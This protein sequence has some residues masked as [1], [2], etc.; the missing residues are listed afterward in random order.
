MDTKKYNQYNTIL[1]WATFVIAALVYTL[2]MEPTASFWDCGEFITTS[3]KLE[4]GHPP[5]APFFM[6]LGRIFSLFAFGD[7]S[8]V[9]MMINLLSALASAFTILFLFWSLTHIARKI[10]VKNEKISLTNTILIFGSAFVGALAYTFSDTFWFSAV[11]GEV[12]ALSS[13]FTAVVFWAILKWENEA[14]SQHANRWLIL[15][16]YL[17]G[18]S[19]G[20][21]LLNLLAIP[22]I[23]FV[24]YFKKH[25]TDVKGIVYASL[26]SIALL[27]GIMYGIIP[28]VI[29]IAAK[30]E[31]LFVNGFGMPFHSG[32]IF[33]AFLLST[34]IVGGLYYTHKKKKVLA[35]T[36]LLAFTVI[37]IGYSSF[38]MIVIRS[39]ANPPM[40]QNSPENVFT[41]L[42]YLNREQYGDRPLI[43]GQY[44]NAPIRGYEEGDPIYAQK[45]GKYE[46]IDKK[47]IRKYDRAFQSIFPR[48]YSDQ[49]EGANHVQGYKDWIGLSTTPKTKP[50]FGQNLKFF[51]KY[52]VGWMYLRYFM[53]NF[54]GRQNDIQGHGEVLHGNW[55]SGIPFIDNLR[56]GDQS[57]LP[58]YLKN[59]KG[60]NTYF[61]LPLLLGLLGVFYTY[62]KDK[63]QFSIISLLFI[64]T[65]VAIV[66]Y[67]N[68]TPY[69]PRERDYAYAASFYAFS[70]FIGLGVLGLFDL[71]KKYVSPK[72][73]AIGTSLACVLFV[74]VIMGAQNWDDHDRSN[75]YTAR[76]FAKN[77]LNSCAENAILFTNG[78]NDTFPL[79][80]AQE[81]E[82]IRTDVRVINL[83]YL[84]TDWYIDQMKRKAYL[85]DPVPFSMSLE[86]YG[87]GKRDVVYIMESIKRHYNIR[88][89]IDFVASDERKTKAQQGNE[90]Y[91]IMPSKKFLAPVDS[92]KVLQN[93]TVSP[94]AA[95]LI[96]DALRWETPREHIRKNELMV[97]DLLATNNWERPIYFAITV[98]PGSYMNLQKYFQLDG[99]AYR[100]VPIKTE[101][102]FGETGRVDTD[103]LYENLM[104]KFVWG[105]IDNPDVYLDENNQRMLMNMKSNFARLAM[106]LIQEGKR[107]SAVNVLDKCVDLMPNKNVPYNYYNILLAEAYYKANEIQKANEMM[108]ILAQT[109]YEELDFLLSLDAEKAKFVTNNKQRDL[110]ILA[111]IIRRAKQYKQT[112]L[113]QET[114][115]KFSTLFAKYPSEFK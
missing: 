77:Y 52:Q 82:G 63:E 106:E 41:L 109:T 54:A 5:G 43:Y 95:H 85:S 59:N 68:Q 11:E 102:K 58:E 112:E 113:A 46:A 81:V 8:K 71:I 38:T 2:T 83:S 1:G 99:M 86:Q 27:G 115:Q 62:K 103:V 69:Q 57:K 84:N 114:D 67:L 78:D 24:Y 7:V 19:I 93:G 42:S 50:S 6:I 74:P 15:I 13:L 92:L 32:A 23:V 35:N 21:H 72:S 25:K 47:I 12:Y 53:W 4:V 91:D 56:L 49:K 16:A 31:Y 33:Y 73:G 76:D 89:L 111:E 40:D 87:Q 90:I 20:V 36:I 107:D 98:G 79:W 65:G 3:Y 94:K 17:I 61:F 108:K 18:L 45:N 80:Y 75:R 100:L 29:K 88:D 97:L 28:G 51:F 101:S 96:V 22:A 104:N 30:F 37:L 60:R 44:F 14:D 39:F 70:M 10:V 66:V 48:I 110:A 34:V 64:F 26:I 9:A 55:I 105:G